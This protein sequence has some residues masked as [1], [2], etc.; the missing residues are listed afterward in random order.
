MK[1][2]WI[3]EN[4]VEHP[5]GSERTA[6]VQRAALNTV[7]KTSNTSV[8]AG[9]NKLSLVRQSGEDWITAGD[10]VCK[11]AGTYQIS[12]NIRISVVATN[13]YL[14]FT[15]NASTLPSSLNTNWG[16][17]TDIMGCISLDATINLVE[18][19]VIRVW[20]QPSS[21]NTI[22]DSEIVIAL[23]QQQVA[24]LVADG[25]GVVSSDSPGKVKI[26]DDLTMQVN[27]TMKW[28]RRTIDVQS[29]GSGTIL[30]T[31]FNLG[32]SSL[33]T[34]NANNTL[35]CN[36]SGLYMMGTSRIE[37]TT[38]VAAGAQIYCGAGF[39]LMPGGT[40]GFQFPTV[41]SPPYFRNAGE[42]F[43]LQS[44]FPAARTIASTNPFTLY[45]AKLG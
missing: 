13:A 45:I 27:P 7:T 34:K 3:D 41:T 15:K 4:G 19:D 31:T 11:Q 30:S 36:E 22:A 18:G 40:D 10:F 9:W 12:A 25:N 43:S 39:G 16:A 17:S 23:L 44:Y 1:Q 35:Q 42:T 37:F 26:L 33:I 29:C 38:A 32:D 21:A 6:Y 28:Q 14:C 24:H 5:V 20:F 2:S 8:V